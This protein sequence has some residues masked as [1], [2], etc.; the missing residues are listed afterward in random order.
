MFFR[1]LL[2]CSF[3]GKNEAEVSKLVAGP[4]VYICN[5]CAS[6]VGRIIDGSHES[7]APSP[8]KSSRLQR[9]LLRLVDF[10]R[11]RGSGAKY[12]ICIAAYSITSSAH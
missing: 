6:I 2:H 10:I 3:C 11:C 8:I 5:E 9:N 12:Q 4:H 1:K 7:P